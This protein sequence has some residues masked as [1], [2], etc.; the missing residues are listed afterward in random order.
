MKK[1]LLL[2]AICV[3]TIAY[4]QQGFVDINFGNGGFISGKM[5]GIINTI[6]QQDDGKILAAGSFDLKYS[7]TRF[8]VNGIVDSTFG[9]NGATISNPAGGATDML[10]TKAGKILICGSF[11]DINNK[12]QSFVA[13]FT[14]AGEPDSSFGVNGTSI[15]PLFHSFEGY[16][17]MSLSADGSIIVGG[18]GAT[19]TLDSQYSV[20]IK[21]SSD[22]IF[23]DTFGNNGYVLNLAA[24]KMNDLTIQP[25]GKI[26]TAGQ[27]LGYH[28]VFTRYNTD[29][30][31]DESF[32]DNGNALLNIGSDDGAQKII[33]QTNGKIMIGGYT[34]L[35][36]Y[37]MLA[38]RLDSTG[39]L[40]ETFGDGGKV[41][42]DFEDSTGRAYDMAQQP[43]G[44]F[45]L[46]G[47][48]YDL[49]Q[50]GG[51]FGLCR[52]TNEGKLDS[53]FGINGLQSTA[54][55]DFGEAYCAVLQ[56]DGKII[57]G[58]YY[59][60]KNESASYLMVRYNNDFNQKQILITKIKKWVQHRNGFTWDANT[61]ISSYVIQRSYDGIHFNSIA[62]MNMHNQ[63]NLTYVDP[64]PL[65]GNSYYRLQTT[66]V[67]GAVANSNIIAVT[68]DALNV[69]LSPN[70]A[71]NTLSIA[72]LPANE[73]VKL[74]VLDFS[75][76]VMLQAIANASSY[77]LN[78]A[79][80]HTGNYVIKMDIH[81]EV[82]SK[83]FVKE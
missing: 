54:F 53:S 30:R 41:L 50:N 59:Q 7:I 26:V 46:A 74:T 82:V 1:I 75:G 57:L 31:L 9:N 43:D 4:A 70:P 79:S 83:Q 20:V 56:D 12:P 15:I 47:A 23:D 49:G 51:Y 72:G 32:G 38:L 25:D 27:N 68:N 61:S 48:A 14:P 10:L 34:S 55:S 29:G 2:V 63:K 69:S 44:K 45:I 8:L 71:K 80:L 64:T 5:P 40:D 28:F 19:K 33:I 77:N 21:L 37:K 58:G 67:D 13:R 17:E 16:S 42:V 76:N 62:K 22:G 18:F 52:I 35:G 81:G 60:Q 39:T 24:S 6:I 73:K 36:R 11:A 66:S 3:S 65:S 78:I